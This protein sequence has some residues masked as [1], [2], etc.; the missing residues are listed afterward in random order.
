MKQINPRIGTGIYYL[1]DGSDH[2]GHCII[3]FVGLVGSNSR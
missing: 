3:L 2:Y 1:A